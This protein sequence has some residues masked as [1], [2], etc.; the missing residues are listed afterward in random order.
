LATEFIDLVNKGTSAGGEVLF[1][2]TPGDLKTCAQHHRE[3]RVGA[4]AHETHSVTDDRLR[5]IFTCCHPAQAS[6]VRLRLAG[7]GVSEVVRIYDPADFG[8]I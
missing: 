1:S 8:T 3:V 4:V 5:L 7:D 6:C 2:R